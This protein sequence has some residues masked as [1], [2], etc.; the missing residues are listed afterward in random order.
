MYDNHDIGV[1]KQ[2]KDSI[3]VVHVPKECSTLVDNH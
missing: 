3:L 2:E 1:Y